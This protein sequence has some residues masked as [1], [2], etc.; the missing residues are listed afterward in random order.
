MPDKPTPR[1]RPPRLGT[2]GDE[3]ACLADRLAE[4]T[5]MAL[6]AQSEPPSQIIVCERDLR[7]WADQLRRG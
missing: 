6:A 5:A 4:L 1:Q 3:V 2:L 7:R